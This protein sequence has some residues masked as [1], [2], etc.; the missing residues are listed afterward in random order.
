M[1][2]LESS[3]VAKDGKKLGVETMKNF[4]FRVM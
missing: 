1:L 2:R 4:K 3:L